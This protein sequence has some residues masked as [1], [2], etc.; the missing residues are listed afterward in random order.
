[1]E[2]DFMMKREQIITENDTFFVFSYPIALSS[3]DSFLMKFLS[4]KCINPCR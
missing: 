3:I 1:M 4:T 2:K